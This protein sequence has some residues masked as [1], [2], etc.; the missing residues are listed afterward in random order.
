MSSKS[1]TLNNYKPFGTTHTSQTQSKFSLDQLIAI[2]SA[3]LVAEM[4]FISGA[5]ESIDVANQS[6]EQ[7]D[8]CINLDLTKT[9]PRGTSGVTVTK[10]PA[11]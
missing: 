6:Y 9:S 5:S 7:Y 2:C 10:F 1:Q 11:W 3:K 4:I 8:Q